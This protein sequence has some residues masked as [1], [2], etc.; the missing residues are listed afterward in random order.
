[1]AVLRV[2]LQY[3][4]LARGA[5]PRQCASR[6]PCLPTLVALWLG[7]R[8][9]GSLVLRSCCETTVSGAADS[10]SVLEPDPRKP[11]RRPRLSGFRPSLRLLSC[12]E[13]V[14]RSEAAQLQRSGLWRKWF[15]RE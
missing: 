1:M 2:A 12:C 6:R 9:T 3:G 7:V 14:P 10:A 13:T 5:L 15:I 4:A 8:D 11:E